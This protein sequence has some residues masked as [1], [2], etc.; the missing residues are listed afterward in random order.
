MQNEKERAAEQF[1]RYLALAED[2]DPD[3]AEI[4]DWLADNRFRVPK[5][6]DAA[7]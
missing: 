6:S 2:D 3:R 7:P 5:R 1:Y 4:E